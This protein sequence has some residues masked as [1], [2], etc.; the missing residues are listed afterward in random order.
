ME[1]VEIF[2]YWAQKTGKHRAKFTKGREKRIK[3]RLKE[4]YS[5]KEIKDAIDG[6]MASQFHMGGNPQNK[7]YNDIEL[8]CRSGEKLESFWDYLS[9]NKP[10]DNSLN[11]WINGN[12]VEMNHARIGQKRI[13]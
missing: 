9:V 3:D 2:N 5:L 6:C 13:S 10:V 4:G 1:H 12:V 11:N 8:I 7:L